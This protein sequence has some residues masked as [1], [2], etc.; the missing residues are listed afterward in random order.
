MKTR[1]KSLP[2]PDSATAKANALS[3][4][5]AMDYDGD[6]LGG[7]SFAQRKKLREESSLST[8]TSATSFGDLSKRA[9]EVILSPSSLI[10]L[11][12]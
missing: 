10:Y 6:L 2:P 3:S 4:S 11:S 7:A 1:K 8:S 5:T 9:K 12:H